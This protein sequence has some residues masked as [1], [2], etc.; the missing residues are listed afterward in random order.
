MLHVTIY[1]RT[2]NKIK[3]RSKGNILYIK[4]IVLSKASRTHN[5]TNKAI[6]VGI[7]I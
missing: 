2:Y 4:Q 1:E 6:Y 3:Y 7:R 5:K